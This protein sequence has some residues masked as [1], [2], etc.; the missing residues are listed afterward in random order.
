[1][2]PAVDVHLSTGPRGE[3]RLVG[4]ARFNLRR[5][6]VSTMFSY[7]E[8]YLADPSSF[9]IDPALPLVTSSSHSDGL[10]GALRDSLPDRWGRHLIA[11]QLR[12]ESK[13]QL[14]TL[15]DVDY[16]LGVHDGARQGALQLTAPDDD[17][18]LSRL[19][20]VPPRI[21]LKRLI[22][23]SNNVALGSGGAEDIK[24]LLE[25]GSG[26]LGGARPKASVI[27][28]D[29]LLLAKFSHPGD[30]WNVMAWEK[31][32]LEVAAAAN[33]AS[34]R[35]QLIRID[36]DSSL[37]LERFDREGSL[38]HGRR[39]PYISAMTLL[40]ANDGEGRDYAEVAESLV[41]LAS[42]PGAELA[43]LFSR[44]A[45][46][47]AL[48]NTDDHLRNLGFLRADG[49]W[50]LAPCFD[51][52]P[53]P[54]LADMR[55]TTVFGEAGGSEAEGLAELAPTCGLSSQ[56]AAERVSAILDAM[57]N[58]KRIARRCGCPKA[59]TA[60]FEPVFSDRCTALEK[61]FL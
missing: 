37:L 25:A 1:M 4:R 10:P 38:F 46:S 29:K 3:K 45:L 24:A 44:V 2:T 52:N 15:D 13:G 26:S 14:R 47:I 11:K 8:S 23:A 50:R 57:G 36:T 55:S 28:E 54:R 12:S 60:L 40:G 49:A 59:E 19:G 16:L 32:A 20:N 7:D 22:A 51:I 43:E 58:W 27:D 21:D 48:H 41:D 9:P 39:I 42:N 53:N 33:I 61:A 5:G 34:P 6:R 18:P 17:I 35:S 30:E 56:E 31:F